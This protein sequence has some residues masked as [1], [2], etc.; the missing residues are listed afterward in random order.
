MYAPLIHYCVIVPVEYCH[1]SESVLFS[2]VARKISSLIKFWPRN[3]PLFRIYSLH[4]L[5]RRKKGEKPVKASRWFMRQFSRE[6]KKKKHEN[7]S[8]LLSF[9]RFDWA[10]INKFIKLYWLTTT[11]CLDKR[12]LKRHF[13]V[14]E[15]K[16]VYVS[17]WK[18]FFIGE[19]SGWMNDKKKKFAMK[20]ACMS[21]IRH[22]LYAKVQG[23]LGPMDDVEE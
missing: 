22:E 3:F 19:E 23:Y 7:F 10:S 1:R 15:K 20:N 11:Y 2:A 13:R 21:G 8:V 14:S 4:F 12:R 5:C 16:C 18:S 6:K 17:G 9:W